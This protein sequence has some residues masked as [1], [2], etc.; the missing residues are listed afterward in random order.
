VPKRSVYLPAAS[1]VAR[2]FQTTDGCAFSFPIRRNFRS[3]DDPLAAVSKAVS[4]Q[5][6]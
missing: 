1:V 5:L 6:R 3:A 2:E 4:G